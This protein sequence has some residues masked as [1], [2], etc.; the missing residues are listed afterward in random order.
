[1]SR[2]EVETAKGD[3]GILGQQGG[4]NETLN[5]DGEKNGGAGGQRQSVHRCILKE[6]EESKRKRSRAKERHQ[7]TSSC[8]IV[9]EHKSGPG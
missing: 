1:M 9:K 7:V 2:G 4:R 8:S 6:Y 5:R 3:K